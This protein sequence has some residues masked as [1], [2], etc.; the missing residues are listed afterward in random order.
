LGVILLG[1]AFIVLLLGTAR[2]EASGL[3]QKPWRDWAVDLANLTVQGTLV[4]VLQVV[5]V[6]AALQWAAP[7]LRGSLDLPGWAAFL[8]NVVGVDYLYYW[9]HRLMHT[10]ALWPLHR[11]HHTVTHMDV[12]ATSRNTL[13]STLFILYLWV[14]G[15]M[16]FLLRDPAPYALGAT[17]TASLDLWR[18]SELHPPAW[19]AAWLRPW[20]ILPEDHARHH[21]VSVPA[22]NYGS[23]FK[24]WDRWHGTALPD[25]GP[26]EPLGFP[27]PASLVRTL[28]WPF[29]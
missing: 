20:L 10:D 23:N 5:G 29:P 1:A 28:L 3:R 17:L 8:L 22:G 6:V 7:D 18:H 9:N 24:L 21:G 15:L 14:G 11:V 12:L 19:L 16:L 25:F 13:W 27:F 4:P 26:K 2:A